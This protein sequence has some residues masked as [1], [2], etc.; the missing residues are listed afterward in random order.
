MN[1]CPSNRALK[2]RAVKRVDLAR[3]SK[4][5]VLAKA[6]AL[7]RNLRMSVLI[8]GVKTDLIQNNLKK[9]FLA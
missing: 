4:D 1:I 6:S 3:K 5:T 7:A 8:A 9:P 2:K